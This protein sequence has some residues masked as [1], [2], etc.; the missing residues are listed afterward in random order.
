MHLPLDIIIYYCL[1]V[2][3]YMICS[4]IF[5]NWMTKYI[6]YVLLA[7]RKAFYKS[8]FRTPR[9]FGLSKKWKINIYRVF[10][11]YY[12]GFSNCKK[13]K[14]HTIRGR[15]QTTF[16]NFANYWPPTYLCLHWLTFGLPPTYLSTLTCHNFSPYI[17]M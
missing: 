5:C 6:I 9:S 7:F 16:A 12:L 17:D 8:Y 15:S 3:V 14:M 2:R 1:T 4:D 13:E 10:T 11:S